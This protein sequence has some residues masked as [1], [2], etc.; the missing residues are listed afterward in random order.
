MVRFILIIIIIIIIIIIVN[1]VIVDFLLLYFSFLWDETNKISVFVIVIIIIIIIV[2]AIVAV[3]VL[4]LSLL[5]FHLKLNAL[6][7]KVLFTTAADNNLIFFQYFP[8]KLMIDISCESSASNPL[9]P[10]PCYRAL[11]PL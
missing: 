3:V 4:L 1:A 9:S 8:E 7:L 11:P 6:P 10:I 2:V 5:M